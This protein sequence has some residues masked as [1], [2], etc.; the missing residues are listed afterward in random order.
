MQIIHSMIPHASWILYSVWLRACVPHENRHQHA[1]AHARG[2]GYALPRIAPGPGLHSLALVQH[3]RAGAAAVL[4]LFPIIFSHRRANRDK[5]SPGGGPPPL[6]CGRAPWRGGPRTPAH[7]SA[8]AMGTASRTP[9]VFY[10]DR[11]PRSDEGGAEGGACGFFSFA[12]CDLAAGK[13]DG[14][15]RRE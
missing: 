9:P 4:K 3:H 14:D 1:G 5:A 2:G 6:G 8:A 13:R 12:F 11:T 15:G 10:H 7:C